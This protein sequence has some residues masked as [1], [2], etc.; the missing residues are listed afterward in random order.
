ML[1]LSIRQPKCM[2]VQQTVS[3]RSN[4]IEST[5][6]SN[7]YFVI[8]NV[9]KFLLLFTTPTFSNRREH[10]FDIFIVK[11]VITVTGFILLYSK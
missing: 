6:D 11:Y 9:A 8:C 1:I 7:Y 3:Q 10:H 4:K 2:R 5:T